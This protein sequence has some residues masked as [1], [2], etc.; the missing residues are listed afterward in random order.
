MEAL[1][2]SGGS[3]GLFGEQIMNIPVK[4]GML[5]RHQNHVYTITDVQEHH[6]GKSRPTYHVMLR[7]IEDGH[8]VN[9]SL[10]QLEPIEEVDHAIRQMQFLYVN[11]KQRVFMDSESFE[12]FE[13][14]AGHLHGCEPFLKEG[15]TYRVTTVEGQPVALDMPDIIK[16]QVKT[17]AAPSHSVGAAS[18]VLKE[19][20][21]ENDLTVNVPLFIKT[22]DTLRV[23]TRTKT[24]VGK[25]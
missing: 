21:L 1:G 2:S 13:L 22:G 3:A 17:T 24:Y 20:L 16:L 5:I 6:S 7:A 11:G 10:D 19:A 8:Q 23:D 18:N 4:R 9:R 12:E 15:E 14:T 25:E